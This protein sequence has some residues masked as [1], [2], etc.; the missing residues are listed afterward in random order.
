MHVSKL[1]LIFIEETETNLRW[2]C[3]NKTSDLHAIDQIYEKASKDICSVGC[4]CNAGKLYPIL[5]DFY[6]YLLVG[7]RY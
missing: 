3:D 4:P 2:E 1:L 6:S 7:I 5:H